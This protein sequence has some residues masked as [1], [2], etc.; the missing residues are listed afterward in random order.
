MNKQRYYYYNY[1][2]SPKEAMKCSISTTKTRSSRSLMLYKIGVL[3]NFAKFSRKHLSWRTAIL[4]KM[5]PVQVFFC[6]F[7]E[8]LRTFFLQ[9]IYGRLFN[10]S[11]SD[12]RN[13]QHCLRFNAFIFNFDNTEWFDSAFLCLAW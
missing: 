3:Q 2:E 9:M 6:E 11:N 4:S 13:R 1:S 8:I 10:V 5:T 7:Y 12:A